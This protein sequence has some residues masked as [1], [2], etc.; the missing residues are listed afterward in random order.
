MVMLS[1]QAVRNVIG[2]IGNVISF[3]LF[4]SPVP[5]F[6]QIIKKKAVEQFS[7]IP[8]LATLLNCMMW[9]LYGLPIVH[10]HSILVV[11]INGIGL[12][13][14]SA[15]LTIFFIYAT[16]EGRLKVLKIL[17]G[18][19]AFM[20]VVVVA[21]LLAA[22]THEKRSLIVGILCIIFGTCM[23]ASPLAVMV[24]PHWKHC[25]VRASVI[26]ALCLMAYPRIC[27][28]RLTRSGPALRVPMD[29]HGAI[30]QS[31]AQI[32][33]TIA[34]GFYFICYIGQERRHSDHAAMCHR[35]IGKKLVI[36]TKSVEY[37]P[38]TLSLASFL[39]GACWT[40]YS[41][42][43]FDINLFIP[44]GLGALFGF[45][46]LILYACY[47]KSTPKKVAKAEVELHS[48]RNV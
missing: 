23:Y 29:N 17:A 10:P 34:A 4:L 31:L 41:C 18:E 20:T 6:V 40:T 25:K 15:Y 24:R 28:G 36:Q 27:H 16:R 8:Y 3:G 30:A 1:Q 43:P 32:V 22:H 19:L 7:P 33:T 11:T 44:N 21:V 39:N 46:Q 9:F 5:T 35:R 37:M 12:V 42:L 48:A 13:I 26:A 14:E 45:L 47:F 2:L 38:F